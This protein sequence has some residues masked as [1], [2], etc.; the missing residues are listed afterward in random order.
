MF[1][2]EYEISM[3]SLEGARSILFVEWQWLTIFPT[4]HMGLQNR[5]SLLLTFSK[6]EK[7]N[8]LARQCHS[9]LGILTPSERFK[10][11]YSEKKSACSFCGRSAQSPRFGLCNS[12]SGAISVG[13]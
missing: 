11:G 5:C 1:V 10:T 3:S 7:Q 12:N 9:N 6:M 2:K 8:W 4:L 13:G